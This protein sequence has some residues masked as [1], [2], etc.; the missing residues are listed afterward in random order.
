MPEPKLLTVTAKLLALSLHHEENAAEISHAG[1][2][3]VIAVLRRLQH[4]AIVFSCQVCYDNT[5][6]SELLVIHTIL[7]HSD[8]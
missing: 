8:K 1:F 4:P 2:F 3:L 6:A 7:L 5:N